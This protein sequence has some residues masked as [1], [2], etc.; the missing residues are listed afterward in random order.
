MTKGEKIKILKDIERVFSQPPTA[1]MGNHCGICAYLSREKPMS[2]KEI[3]GILNIIPDEHHYS[4]WKFTF[5]DGQAQRV[6]WNMYN[7]KYERRDWA[8]RA[9]KYLEEK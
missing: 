6:V 8:R 4:L 7:R 3:K 2:T 1:N 9:I 5:C